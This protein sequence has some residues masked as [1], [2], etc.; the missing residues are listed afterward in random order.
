VEKA[1]PNVV[2]NEKA[3]LAEREERMRLLEEEL[4]RGAA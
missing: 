2:A 3:K 4:R 1:P